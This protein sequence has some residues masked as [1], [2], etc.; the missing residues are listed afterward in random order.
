MVYRSIVQKKETER[1][2]LKCWIMGINKY[3]LKKSIKT[4]ANNR[5]IQQEGHNA[6]L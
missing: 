3:R 6:Q 1:Q 2:S 4:E 5:I